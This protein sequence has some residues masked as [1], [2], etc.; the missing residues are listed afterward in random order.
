MEN[1]IK[2]D[3]VARLLAIVLLVILFGVIE[4]T[5]YAFIQWDFNPANWS[6]FVRSVF[7][8]VVILTYF[9]VKKGIRDQ[10]KKTQ[11]Q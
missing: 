1:E 7:A 6:P 8:I 5:L 2:I 11:S 9:T 10:H 3:R 4:Y